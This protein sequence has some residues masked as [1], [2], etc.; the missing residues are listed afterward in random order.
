MSNMVDVKLLHKFDAVGDKLPSPNNMNLFKFNA[1][2][3]LSTYAGLK[4]DPS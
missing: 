3:S 4:D 2:F 1:T